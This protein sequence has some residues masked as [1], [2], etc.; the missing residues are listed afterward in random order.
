MGRRFELIGPPRRAFDIGEDEFIAA[1]ACHHTFV[2][3]SVEEQAV[4]VV[5]I[6]GPS[7]AGLFVGMDRMA[8][9]RHANKIL[10]AVAGLGGP[11]KDGIE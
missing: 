1:S 3:N 4:F 10:E 5:F 2:T 7:G 6:D 9:T 11:R 8:A